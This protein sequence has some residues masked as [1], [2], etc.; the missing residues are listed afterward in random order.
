MEDRVTELRSIRLLAALL[1]FA[2]TFITAH[3]AAD[4]SWIGSLAIVGGYSH[5][6]LPDTDE[7]IPGDAPRL[8]GAM[9]SF[10]LSGYLER[11]SGY[12]FGVDLMYAG[13]SARSDEYSADWWD[14]TTLFV[15]GYAWRFD[16]FDIGPRIG[17]GT[18]TMQ[19]VYRARAATSARDVLGAASGS[20]SIDG[21]AF[22]VDGKL[23]ARYHFE[24]SH[25]GKGVFLGVLGGYSVSPFDT[26]WRYFGRN[27]S[28]GPEHR[29]RSPYGA[30]T[31][32]IEF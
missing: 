10:G 3:A 24:R 14:S 31:F 11:P 6:T 2:A 17:G 25:S 26:D 12:G 13:G 8:D 15:F 9:P 16:R 21:V 20:G 29:Y 30:L 19:Y 18:A 22:V 7:V 32:G 27:V 28:G 4:S 1:G 23:H 5:R